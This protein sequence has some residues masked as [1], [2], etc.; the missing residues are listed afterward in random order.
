VPFV[1]LW[2]ESYQHAR[3][4]QEALLQRGIVVEALTARSIR[5]NGAVVRIL[6]SS[7]HTDLEVTR[8]LDSLLEIRKRTAGQSVGQPS[9]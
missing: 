9:E 2:F 8:L 4:I 5:R 7:G 3:A 1:S 6:L